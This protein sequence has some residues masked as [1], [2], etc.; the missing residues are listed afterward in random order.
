MTGIDIPFPEIQG[1]IHQ[2]TI[3]EISYLG[4]QCFTIAVGILSVDKK[5]YFEEEPEL[6]NQVTNFDLFMELVNA[7]GHS[8]ER[9]FLINFLSILFPNYNIFFTPQSIILNNMQD[10]I[11]KI[12]DVDTFPI[13]Q[14][15]V[16]DMFCLNGDKDKQLNPKGKRATEI[17]RKMEKMRAKI[18][19]MNK[20][21]SG[22][23]SPL[24]T[25]VSCLA[26]GLQYSLEDLK[27]MTVYQIYDLLKRYSLYINWDMDIRIRLTP[28]AQ[29]NGEVEDW[30]RN[31]H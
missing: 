6:L 17:A 25:Y 15:I 27:K 30:M 3:L 13:F 28:G 4:E 16:K 22:N 12:I 1:Q 19:Q 18:A 11:Q 2:P 24:A 14:E 20:D 23:E 8:E 26:V 7:D 9:E 31:I 21:K 29:A 5:M 10:N